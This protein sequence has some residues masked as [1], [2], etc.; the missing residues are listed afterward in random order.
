MTDDPKKRQARELRASRE[1]IK[2][3][4]HGACEAHFA[5]LCTGVGVHAH[6]RVLRSQ[7]VVNRP[8]MLLWVCAFCHH[9]IH[10]RQA[11]AREEGLIVSAPHVTL[12]PAHWGS[13]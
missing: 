9:E 3:R 2:D 7:A 10:H 4:S 13:E 8:D 12:I 11:E 1:A 5:E 6:H